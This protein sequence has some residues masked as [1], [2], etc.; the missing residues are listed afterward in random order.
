M[1]VWCK[2]N[3]LFSLKLNS[4][5]TKYRTFSR[6]LLAIYWPIRNVL[7]I[8]EEREFTVLTEHKPLTYAMYSNPKNIHHVKQDILS[9]F[10]NFFQPTEF[11]IKF[12][13][14][15]S[16]FAYCYILN[17]YGYFKLYTFESQGRYFTATFGHS[18]FLCDMKQVYPRPYMHPSLR[19]KYQP[20]SWIITSWYTSN[21]Q[22]N[23]KAMYSLSKIE[24]CET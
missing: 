3:I 12:K 22:S 7:Y 2:K 16:T 24:N 14:Y 21:L 20:T 1:H 9:I 4:S 11:N 13:Y 8:L 5:R 23:N 15:W 6:E 19:K 10:H 18:T 17:K